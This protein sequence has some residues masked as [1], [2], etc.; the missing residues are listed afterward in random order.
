MVADDSTRDDEQTLIEL[1]SQLINEGRHPQAA[2]VARRVIKLAPS[3]PAGWFLMG[4]ASLGLGEADEAELCLEKALRC[5]GARLDYCQRMAEVCIQRGDMKK[6]AEWCEQGIGL[7][8]NS[9]H[10]HLTLGRAKAFGGDLDGACESLERCVSLNPDDHRVRA[11]LGTLYLRKN[12][13][14]AAIKQFRAALAK[15]A[16]MASLWNNLGHALSRKGE[17]LEAVKAF[18]KAVGLDP[19]D[20]SHLCNLGDGYLALDEPRMAVAVL[21]QA[22]ERRPDFPLAHYDLGLA[23]LRLGKY[24]EGAAASRA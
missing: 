3:D 14:G 2:A 19:R 7:E 4:S 24:E 8:R 21:L 9:L 22:V 11:E 17:K 23:F 20:A 15:D 12:D 10:L 13:Y 18:I 5:D 6:A 16:T 1:A